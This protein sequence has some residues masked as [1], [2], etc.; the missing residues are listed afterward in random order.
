M[1]GFITMIINE[2]TRKKLIEN[3][4]VNLNN[5][6]VMYNNFID[7]L[8]TVKTTEEELEAKRLLLVEYLHKL[9]LKANYCQFCLENQY[10]VACAYAKYHKNCNDSNSDWREINDLRN[11]LINQIYI[12]YYREEEY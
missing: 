2:E 8:K 5:I 1:A 3:H 11:T 10:C 9:P 4:T 12:K 6:I 7:T